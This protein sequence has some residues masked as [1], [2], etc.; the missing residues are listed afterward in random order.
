MCGQC[1]HCLPG[2][3]WTGQ[4]RGP[5]ASF[6]AGFLCPF[7]WG[8]CTSERQEHAAQSHP[9]PT[10]SWRQVKVFLG[11]R[12]HPSCLVQKALEKQWQRKIHKCTYT[13]L[14]AARTRELRCSNWLKPQPRSLLKRRLHQG[15]CGQG[16]G[17]AGRQAAGCLTQGK[18]PLQRCYCWRWLC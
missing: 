10:C 7:Q 2:A 3:A 1:G 15:I 9:T 11:L 6:S 5:C 17:R 18:C 13:H 16:G 4:Q 14:H 12:F 8:V